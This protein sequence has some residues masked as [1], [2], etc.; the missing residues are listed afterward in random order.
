[1]KILLTGKNGQ[2]GWGLQRTLSTLGEVIACDRT[3]MD[4]TNEDSIVNK[5]RETKPHIIVNAAAYTAVDKAEL[6][7]DLAMAVNGAAP[8]IIAEEAR[9]LGAAV[10]HYST[11]YVFDG[12]KDSPY[13]EEDKTNPINVYGQTKLA[14]EDAIKSAEVPYYIF[15]T[16][17][18]YSNRGKNFVNTM[19][20]LA[21]ERDEI[22]IVS[23]QIGSPTWSFTIAEA[24]SQIIAQQITNKHS[25]K[26]GILESSGIYHL[27]SNEYTS[28]FDFANAIFAND[29]VHNHHDGQLKIPT[30]IPIGTQEFPTPAL[31]PLCSRLSNIKI[32]ETFKIKCPSWLQSL[33][34][35]LEEMVIPK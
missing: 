30:I 28:W 25:C 2:V 35:C 16:S 27:T 13:S 33:N 32:E 9:K 22:R 15:R 31:R 19:L 20:T 7:P 6:E 4:L 1:M 29:H 18:V 14:G 17:W 23:D 34:L 21:K 5:I 26:S 10:I 12:S 11:D 24:T 3:E 8:G